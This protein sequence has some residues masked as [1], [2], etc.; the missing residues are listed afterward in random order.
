MVV[1]CFLETFTDPSVIWNNDV[2]FLG[3]VSSR[4]VLIVIVLLIGWISCFQLDSIEGS[5]RVFAFG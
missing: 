3:G 5:C 1:T 2:R 4:F